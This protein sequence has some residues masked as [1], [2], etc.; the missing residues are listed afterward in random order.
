MFGILGYFKGQ[1]TEYVIRYSGGRVAQ[2]GQAI[3]FVYLRPSTSIVSVPTSSADVGFIFHEQ[4][5][6]FQSVAVQG[7]FT[8]RIANPRQAA[9]ILNFTID[10]RRRKYLTDD[11]DKLAQRITNILQMET[12][13]EVLARS[14]EETLRESETMAGAVL[15]RVRAQGL[16]EPMGV[17]LLSV[18]F[19]SA[20]P[21]PEVAKALEAEYR[22]TL[23]RNA[24]EAIY[25]RRAAAV[26]EERRIK[27]N[28]LATDIALEEQRQQFIAL[29]GGNARQEAEFRGQALEAEAAYRSRA[30]A[31]ELEQYRT[32][33]PRSTLALA[34]RDMG[35]NADKVGNLTIT[36]EILASLMNGRE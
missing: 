6:N 35:Q 16:L 19:L 10:P 15:T 22:E 34:L 8:Y 30:L 13:R 2:E 23:L 28:E 3:S 36:S 33:D 26:E 5:G 12:R 17:E 14:L 25:A 9:A 1:P 11:P 24:D 7:Q 20:K 21:T 4:T 29:E 27:E 32:V 18:Y 31:M